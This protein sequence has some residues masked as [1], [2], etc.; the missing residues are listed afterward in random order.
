MEIGYEQWHD[1]IS[2]DL[3]ALTSLDQKERSEMEKRLIGNL[4]RAGDW[5]DVEALS[6]L[7]SNSARAA[8]EQARNHRAAEVRHQALRTL[9]RDPKA[10]T[11]VSEQE[12]EDQLVREVERG[13]YR[14]A[15]CLPTEKVKRALLQCARDD[16]SVI[17]VHAAALL[18]YLCGQAPE[19]FDW[20]QRSFFLLFAQQDPQGLLSAWEELRRRTGQ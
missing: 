7:R 6:V 19:P 13:S 2:Y 5:R 3:Q 18:L 12:L 1:G 20:N 4:K 16:R 17:R 15:E 9:L 14:L 11:T 10:R 8:V